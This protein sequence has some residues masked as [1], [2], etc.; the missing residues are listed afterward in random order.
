MEFSLLFFFVMQA[1][2]RNPTLVLPSKL[3]L[4]KLHFLQKLS[5]QKPCWDQATLSSLENKQIGCRVEQLP[6]TISPITVQTGSQ[7]EGSVGGY[8]WLLSHSLR[9][10]SDFCHSGF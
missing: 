7:V 10:V 5:C 3:K 1:M 8:Y 9:E 2:Q 4:H 6:V